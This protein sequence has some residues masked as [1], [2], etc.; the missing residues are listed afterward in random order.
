MYYSVY[1]KKYFLFFRHYKNNAHWITD[2][3]PSNHVAYYDAASLY[4]SSGKSYVHSLSLDSILGI[5]QILCVQ[6]L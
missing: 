4:P 3:Q 5:D 6:V 1:Y 2:A